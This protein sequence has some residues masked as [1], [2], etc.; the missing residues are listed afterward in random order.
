MNNAL[1]EL[2]EEK[3][4]LKIQIQKLLQDFSDKHNVLLD[5]EVEKI[6]LQEIGIKQSYFVDIKIEL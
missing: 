6:K 5:V 4:S 1:K 2:I 3:I